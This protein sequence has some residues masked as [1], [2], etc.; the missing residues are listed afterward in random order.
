[1]VELLKQGERDG[2]MPPRYLLEKAVEQ[3]TTIA[4]PAGEASAFG[5]PASD[6]PDSIPP[7]ERERLHDAVISA[8]DDRFVR[9]TPSWPTSSPAT[10]RPRGGLSRGVVVARR[11]STLSFRGAAVHDHRHVPGRDPRSGA[12]RGRPHRGGAGGHRPRLGFSDLGTF[13]ESLKSDPKL[14]PTSREQIL[15]AYRHYIGQMQPELPKLFGLLPKTPLEVR[16]VQ[17]FREK[18]AAGAEYNMGTPDGSRP[19]V[20]YVNTGDYEHR[21]LIAVEATAY[22]EAVPGHHLQVAIAQTLPSLAPF[23]QYAYYGAY[24]EGWALYSERLGKEIGFYQ[25]PYSDF[26]RLSEELLRAVRLVVD[27]GVHHKRWTRQQ[28]VDYFHEHSDQDEPNV[29]AETDRYIVLPAQALCYKVGQLEILRL[30]DRAREALGPRYDPAYL[31]RQDPRWRSPAARRPRGPRS[32][33]DRSARLT[34]RCRELPPPA[35]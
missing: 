19:G 25:D 32:C 34:A 26:G 21:S 10:T 11:R 18:E 35:V 29:Q 9:P 17:E 2:L 16:P 5:R 20:V 27:T 30:R 3:C 14:Y 12:G 15:E 33:L 24:I 7:A 22:H 8:V 31:P 23:R 28:M 6:M 1:M 13:R 4:G